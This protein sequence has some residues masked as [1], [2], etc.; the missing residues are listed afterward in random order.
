MSHCQHFR[1]VLK[2]KKS[3]T[4]LW[5]CCVQ[6]WVCCMPGCY[7]VMFRQEFAS[8]RKFQLAVHLAVHHIAPGIVAALCT[9]GAALPHR[10]RFCF[11]V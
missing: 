7:K 2:N 5:N 6:L 11:G 1:L 8:R 4:G 3:S 9:A 10:P